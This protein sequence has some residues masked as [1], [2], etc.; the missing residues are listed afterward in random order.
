MSLTTKSTGGGNPM[1][2]EL[3]KEFTTTY[4]NLQLE[5]ND[6]FLSVSISKRGSEWDTE[7]VIDQVLDSNGDDFSI[8]YEERRFIIA[9]F[10][11][12]E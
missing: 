3:T 6:T 2:S 9:E 1:K 5:H 12:L 4:Y 10:K 11:R 8:S 7:I